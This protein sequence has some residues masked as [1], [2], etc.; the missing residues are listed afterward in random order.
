VDLTRERAARLALPCLLVLLIAVG[1]GQQN[2]QGGSGTTTSGAQTTP[3]VP[4]GHY[5]NPVLMSDFADPSVLQV[6]NVFYAY[7]TNAFGKNV[8]VARSND[9]VH[10]DVLPDALPALPSWAA[11][12]GS[13]VWA[14]AVI[15]LGNTYVMYYTARDAQSNKQ[16]VGVATSVEPGGK[17]RDRSSH[18]LV[19]Q[20]DQG[21]TIDPSPLLDGG[22]LY[23][24]FKN[25][26]N[27]CGLTTHLYVQQLTPDGLN[28][29]GRATSLVSNDAAWEGN[30]VEAPDMFKHDGKYYLFFSANDYAGVHYAVGY[31][32]CQTAIG[33]CQKA[34]DNPILSSQVSKPPFVIGPGGESVIQL[35]NQ[36]WV[37]YHAWSVNP[38]GSQGD[39]RYMYLDRITWQNDGPHVQGPTTAPEPDPIL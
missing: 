12:G 11:P 10:W 30:V 25:D 27:C 36:T 39:S 23:L 5:E 18:A 28:S 3:T 17:F 6:G 29:L 7:A 16:C 38:D 4:P 34:P 22:K 32:T 31:A 33:P 8:Q 26:G 37:F 13:Y 9:L 20:V 14:P 35:G 24:Y 2:Q 19:C 1:C 15:Q 21:G